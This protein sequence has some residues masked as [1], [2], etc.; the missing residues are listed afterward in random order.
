MLLKSDL[1]VLKLSIRNM[2]LNDN[3]SLYLNLKR[4]QINMY[5]IISINNFHK[6]TYD[7]GNDAIGRLILIR[8]LG[9][10]L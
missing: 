9:D 2:I 1:P 3:L 8:G 4:E 10:T 5:V 6:K 7:I